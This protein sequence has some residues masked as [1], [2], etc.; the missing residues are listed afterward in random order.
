MT[1]ATRSLRSLDT[2]G[3]AYSV[4]CLTLPEDSVGSQPWFR[5]F[6]EGHRHW[7]CNHPLRAAATPD[8]TGA[9]SYSIRRPSARD[10]PAPRD[11]QRAGRVG[12]GHG[13]AESD[14]G[15]LSRRLGAVWSRLRARSTPTTP[16]ATSP[17][18]AGAGSVTPPTTCRP[19]LCRARRPRS[20]STAR[21]GSAWYGGTSPTASC[22]ERPGICRGWSASSRRTGASRSSGIWRA[23]RWRRWP[24]MSMGRRR[25]G[26]WTIC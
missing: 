10:G 21:T 24:T 8:A 1:S 4:I 12:G 25:A 6:D 20:L 26:A 3:K 19:R 16:T 18:G 15:A 13:R 14:G 17:P 2:F 7:G 22:V 23:V 9:R 11:A 5:R